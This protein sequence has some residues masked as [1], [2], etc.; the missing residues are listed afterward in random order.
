MQS[1]STDHQV[2][3][4]SQ[5]LQGREGAT[6]EWRALTATHAYLSLAATGFSQGPMLINFIETKYV[7]C[8]MQMHNPRLRVATSKETELLREQLTPA[9][10]M[11]LKTEDL[12]VIMSNEGKS[13]IWA[14][15]MGIAEVSE[16]DLAP[17]PELNGPLWEG[18]P[19][20]SDL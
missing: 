4:A 15:G 1:N 19:P 3:H 20:L 2:I 18:G 14:E 9:E 8:P 10:A 13:W 11:E 12:L 16:Q 17:S 6:L 5:R 7:D